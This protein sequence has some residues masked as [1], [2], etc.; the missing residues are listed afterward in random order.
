MNTKLL[1][2]VLLLS[3]SLMLVIGCSER[4]HDQ[5][6]P[7]EDFFDKP[8]HSNFKISPDGKHIAYLG[9]EDHCKNIFVLNLENPD[10]SKQLTYQNS[11]NVQYYFWA[12]QDTIVFSNSESYKDS[13]RLFTVDVH[14]EEIRPLLAPSKH[15][16]D[17]VKPA[18]AFNGS[19]L[20][21]MNRRDSTIIDL[22]RI[23]L[24]GGEPQLV[25]ENIHDFK[26]WFVS[27]DG[28]VR[29]ALSSDSVEDRLWYREEEYLPYRNVLETDF[30]SLVYPLG[31]LKN[32]KQNVYAL[33]NRG[34]D[35]MA[36]VNLD[37]ETG[38][39][40]ILA[41]ND[42]VDMNGDGYSFTRQE[43]LF[44]TA[45]NKKKETVIH[46]EQLK[47][48]YKTISSQ[49]EGNSVDI[50]DVDS[51][52]QTVLFK[53]Y[54][55]TNP[56]GI[57]YYY[58]GKIKELTPIN[59][60]L[61]NKKL[62][63]MEEVAFDSRD[64]KH[65]KGYITYPLEK[66]DKYPVVVLVH[67]GPN[68]RDVW[69]FNSEVQFLANRGYA[70]FQVNY[71]GSVGLGKNFYVSGFKQWGGEIQNDIND[72]VAWLIHKGIADKDR[73][74]IMG[75]GFGGYSA[76]YA[77]CFNPTL[78]KC[79][80]SSSGYINLFAYF[81]EFPPYLNSYKQLYYK[82]IGD[83]Q[84]EYELF[85]AISPLFHAEKIR[86]PILMFQGGKDRYNSMTDVNHFVQK[87]KSN[88]VPYQYVLKEDEGR[89]FKKDE[90][91]VEFYQTIEKFLKEQLK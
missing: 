5:K 50:I 38:T 27:S 14:T 83:P 88:N 21:R 63:A 1:V 4:V 71:R 65:I 34:R 40:T 77:A 17:W 8:D 36:V 47:H 18:R 78:Y 6:I 53:T 10:S 57:Y 54:T 56:G 59:P 16:L 80:I 28:K 30:S 55:D 44:S 46:N 49:F 41:K 24:A 20:A 42:D 85:K 33:S 67:D 90:N 61:S 68:R 35:K 2:N 39:E 84:K 9:L 43:L 31:P 79:A 60:A 64:G 15:S 3:I 58:K 89:R 91:I 82:I 76:L 87:L 25:D 69:G 11:M 52:F 74:A 86:M 32:S 12:T 66:K 13:L 29:L 73:I 23:P 22:Y 45:Y 7:I 37:L 72:G 51:S 81:K 26:E 48:I 75:T 70:V 62:P 19:L